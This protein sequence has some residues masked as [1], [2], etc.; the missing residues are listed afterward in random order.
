MT[1]AGSAGSSP[2][3]RRGRAKDGPA[4]EL[5]WL[6][7]RLLRPVLGLVQQLVHPEP[8]PRRSAPRHDLGS[9]VLLSLAHGTRVLFPRGPIDELAFFLRGDVSPRHD[10]EFVTRGTSEAF[11]GHALL[12]LD[13]PGADVALPPL[14][15]VEARWAALRAEH[16]LTGLPRPEP[17]P[18][19]EG[20]NRVAARGCAHVD[21]VRRRLSQAET[22]TLLRAEL[23]V[24]ERIAW[25]EQAFRAPPDGIVHRYYLEADGTPWLVRHTREARRVIRGERAAAAVRRAA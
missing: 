25:V 13:R 17:A 10:L 21:E 7:K 12:R 2:M 4:P 1:R 14:R 8:A 6:Q 15:A 11:E 22:L 20:L 24:L 19:R 16:G 18:G 9:D 23:T 3:A 5:V